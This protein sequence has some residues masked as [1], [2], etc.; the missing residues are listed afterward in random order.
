[1]KS[2]SS[3][4]F[5][6]NAVKFVNLLTPGNFEEANL[7][8][9]DSCEYRYQDQVLKGKDIIK[10]FSDNH[11]NASRKISI[12]YIDGKVNKVEGQT[13]FVR[14]LDKLT[15]NGQSHIYEDC[16][17]ISC[18]NLSGNGSIERIE[19]CPIPEERNKLAQFLDEV[20]IKL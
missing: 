16:L 11:D 4:I 9:S 3:K 18:N 5:T 20:G 14:V 13:V 17:A 10:S 19:H 8:L 2:D 6:E 1:M 7:W 12:E 15:A